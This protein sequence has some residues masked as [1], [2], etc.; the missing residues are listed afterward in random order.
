MEVYARMDNS[1]VIS[2]IVPVYKVEQYLDK[3]VRSITG[4]TYRNLDIIL[5]D[6]GSPDSCGEMCDRFAEED[7]RIRVI[8][9]QNGGLSSARNA[10]MK[11]A[12]GAYFAF[13]DS[14]DWIEPDMYEVMMKTALE[15]DAEMVS[16]GHYI[17]YTD[18]S[19]ISS[20]PD[21]TAYDEDIL[22]EFIKCSFGGCLAWNKLYRSEYFNNVTFPEGQNYEDFATIYKVTFNMH[23]AVSVA[24][25]KYHY[26]QR[27]NS[28]VRM[29]SLKNVRDFWNSHNDW[30]NDLNNNE[31][32]AGD[33]DKET[34]LYDDSARAVSFSWRFMFPLLKENRK[35][36]RA[37][38]KEVSTFARKN[39]ARYNLRALGIGVL[40]PVILAMFNNPLSMAIAYYIN[41][42]YKL[43]SHS[44][45]LF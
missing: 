2:I 4:Q 14:D 9:K 15:K 13:V 38:A 17:D 26:L 18:R 27:S 32:I 37:F 41:A 33:K 44:E 6:D 8:H 40:L 1:P 19:D 10:G 5:V 16:V 35:E 24:A 39:F 12:K 7:S 31:I 25:P 29:R 3:C 22:T 21:L 43:V 45:G 20:N 36:A 30:F 28:I 34:L 23:C 11:I 42:L